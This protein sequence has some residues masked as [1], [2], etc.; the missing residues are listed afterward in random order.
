MDYLGVE[1]KVLQ[2]DALS[3][4]SDLLVLK[5]AQDSYGVDLKAVRVADVDVTALP[6][7]GDSFLIRKPLRI[8]SRDLLFLGVEPLN[9][10]DYRSIREFSRRALV[11]AAGIS[12]PVREISMTLHGAGFGLDETEAFE[13]EV[14]GIVEAL[15]SGRFPRNL[16]AVCIIELNKGRADRMRD[17]LASLLGPDGTGRRT[18]E[19]TATGA[20]SR[21]RRI[22]SVGYDSAARRH[23]FVAMPFTEPFADIFNYGIAPPVRAAGLLCERIDEVHFTGDVISRMRER[24]TSST[25]V[26]ADLS[27]ANPNVYLEVGYAWGINT[28]CILICNRK[29]RLKFDVQGQRCLF[30]GSIM[31]L[32][33]NLSTEL[34]AF[35]DQFSLGVR[36]S[37]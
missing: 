25:V 33:K 29:T 31:E 26:V 20:T 16:R 22:D 11:C 8:A 34:I 36:R 32:E 10:F 17:A 9:N 37:K 4:P 21:P 7:V 35:S 13:S 23:A 19:P 15:D 12:P 5:Y 28:P 14:A 2:D 1:L 27:N 6:I 18:T 30:Y 24:I 3:Y